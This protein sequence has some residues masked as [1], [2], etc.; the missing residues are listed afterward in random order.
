MARPAPNQVIDPIVYRES[1]QCPNVEPVELAFGKHFRRIYRH[2][3]HRCNARL[4]VR[5]RHVGIKAII[6]S[7]GLGEAGVIAVSSRFSKNDGPTLTAC[8][9]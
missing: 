3:R 7:D 6:I 2:S 1:A 9:M 5:P 8:L 4:F